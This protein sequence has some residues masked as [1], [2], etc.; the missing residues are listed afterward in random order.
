MLDRPPRPDWKALSREQQLELIEPHR[1]AGASASE[2]ASL[3]E[4]CTR[5]SI[6]GVCNRAKVKLLGHVHVT[7]KKG[8]GNRGSPKA[9]AIVHRVILR[10]QAE[11]RARIRP[12]K[13]MHLPRVELPEI[14]ARRMLIDLRSGE[15]RWCDG[16]PLTADHSFCGM[17]AR[18]GSS[19]CEAHHARV[20]RSPQQT[21]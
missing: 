21:A 16:D 5:N 13:V 18:P 1:L 3:F 17:P 12:P 19:W 7:K 11:E 10:K 15:C 4:N 8:H 9:Q 20:F 6:I 2:M 14:S